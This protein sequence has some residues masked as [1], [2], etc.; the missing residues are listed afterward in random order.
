MLFRS[1]APTPPACWRNPSGQIGGAAA[2]PDSGTAAAIENPGTPDAPRVIKLTETAALEILGS[3]GAKA[4]SIA[5]KAGETVRFEVENTAG[6]DHNFWI[7][8]DAGLDFLH[9]ESG[10]IESHRTSMAPGISGAVPPSPSIWHRPSAAAYAQAQPE[11]V[12]RLVL[13]AFTYKGDGAAEIARRRARIAHA[14]AENA[15]AA[16]RKSVGGGCRDV[17]L[18]LPKPTHNR[19]RP[20]SR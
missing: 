14:R 2:A 19:D 20:G 11:R 10:R 16:D 17:T 18:R 6:Y 13:V 4:A 5:V 12:D 9:P 1:A 15:A 7:G 3:D 8:T